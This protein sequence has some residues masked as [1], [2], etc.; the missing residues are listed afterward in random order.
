VASR[1]AKGPWKVP[2][3]RKRLR[4][5]LARSIARL[6]SAG[7]RSNY[8]VFHVGG[9]PSQLFVLARYLT[10]HNLAT[11]CVAGSE[12]PVAI[13]QKLNVTGQ[14]GRYMAPPSTIPKSQAVILAGVWVCATGRNLTY[15]ED[16]F[17]SEP[18]ARD[19]SFDGQQSV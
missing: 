3:V 19:A 16:Y 7:D 13:A 6:H 12:H 8:A 18:V 14:G 5:C 10:L 9:L 4:T 15:G 17:G 1:G 2:F 11:Y